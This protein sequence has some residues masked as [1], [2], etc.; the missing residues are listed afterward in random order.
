MPGR[1]AGHQGPG[2]G[3]GRG[4]PGGR[5]GQYA[6]YS[7]E[8]KVRALGMLARGISVRRVSRALTIPRSTL[9]RWSHRPEMVLGTGRVTVL[10]PYEEDLLV[11]AFN[12]V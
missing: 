3:R 11:T 12:F 2:R 7:D 4:A 9:D 5:G 1:G 6:K 8:D 10:A